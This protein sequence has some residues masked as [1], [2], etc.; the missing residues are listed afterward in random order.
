LAGDTCAS[1][2][3]VTPAASIPS[4]TTK[5]AAMKRITG[6]PKPAK[7]SLTVKTPVAKRIKSVKMATAPT[8]RRFQMKMGNNHNE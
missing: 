3:V 5:S 4:L 2:A 7:A 1:A 6:S 8:G